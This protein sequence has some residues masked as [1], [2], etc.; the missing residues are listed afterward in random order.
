VSDVPGA[1]Q[2][3]SEQD[4]KQR[5]AAEKFLGTLMPVGTP[6]RRRVVSAA[7]TDLLEFSSAQELG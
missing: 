2:P 5:K 7:L 1:P 4:A 3:E 6:T